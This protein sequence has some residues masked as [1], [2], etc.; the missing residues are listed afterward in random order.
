MNN[1]STS[2]LCTDKGM[3]QYMWVSMMELL[4]NNN[5]IQPR[6]FGKVGRVVMLSIEWWE[7]LLETWISSPQ[8]QPSRAQLASCPH[9]SVTIAAAIEV[10]V[11]IAIA[12]STE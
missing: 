12:A 7:L 3:N 2:Q 5:T 8:Q 9:G 4:K 6:V 1:T 10:A 11:A